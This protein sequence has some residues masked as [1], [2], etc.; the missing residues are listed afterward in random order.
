MKN[1]TVS[2]II[3]SYNHA[4]YISEAINSVLAQTFTDFELIIVDDCSPDNSVEL[5]KRYND[6]RIR[7]FVNESNQGAVYTT[8]LAIKKAIGK[9]IA[10]LNSDDLWEKHKLEL[11]VNFLE[12]NRD[13][14]AV[15]ANA[16]FINENHKVLSKSE[17]F[18]ADVFTK[19]NRTSAEWLRYFFF[20]FNCLC[21][22]SILIKREIYQ[23]TNLYDPSLRQLPDFKMWVHLLKKIK[24]YVFTEA[25]VIFRVLSNGENASADTSINKIRTRN[26]IFLIMQDFF[27]DMTI[28]LFKQGFSDLLINPNITNED[29]FKCEQAFMYLKMDSEVSYIYKLIAIQKFHE[30]ISEEKTRVLLEKEYS[31]TYRD[32]FEMTGE[33]ELLDS[34]QKTISNIVIESAKK[35][36]EHNQVSYNI[37]KKIYKKLI[38]K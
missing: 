30:L 3:P 13:V 35:R 2:V 10:L 33:Y 4:S 28:D 22:P 36:L 18:W 24:I 11:Q 27:E 31:F 23:D 38:R 6:P 7:L 1:P 12:A 34:S 29:Q 37:L 16:K 32:F 20:N 14:D 15:F 8:N 17:Y 26:E 5:I 9:Y 25:L 21:H 19:D